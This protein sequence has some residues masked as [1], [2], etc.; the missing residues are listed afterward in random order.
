[1]DGAK[2]DTTLSSTSGFFVLNDNYSPMDASKYCY[3]LGTLQY[4][5]LTWLDI[6]YV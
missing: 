4:L 1:M 2:G 5:S 6:S 3:V